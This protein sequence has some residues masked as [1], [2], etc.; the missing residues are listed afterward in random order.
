MDTEDTICVY[1][2]TKKQSHIIDSILQKDVECSNIK[3]ASTE[4]EYDE[5]VKKTLFKIRAEHVTKVW[6]CA[7]LSPQITQLNTQL[8]RLVLWM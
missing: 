7:I 8:L 1:K 4:L 2:P 5:S 6:Y 3:H